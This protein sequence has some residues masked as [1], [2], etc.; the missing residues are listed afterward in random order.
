VLS[1]VEVTNYQSLRKADIRLGRLTVVTGPTGSGKSALFRAIR[2]LALNARG[3][4]YVSHGQKSCSVTAWGSQ[5][6]VRL[7][8]SAA[9][10]GRN[11]YQ[12]AEPGT[13]AARK[14]TKLNSQVPAD[15]TRLLGLS[16]LNFHRQ[17][18]QP[19]LLA[20]PPAEVARKLGELTNVS[21][22]LGAAAE[23]NRL[24]KG[25]Q[26]DLD[27]ARARR[28]ALMEEA[29]E[30]AGLRER[31]RACTAAEEALARA[32][33]AAARAERLR[34]LAGRLELYEAR[35]GQA[36]AEAARQAPPSLERLEALVRNRARLR[37]LTDRLGGEESDA[38]QLR[39]SAASA[40]AAEKAAEQAIHA[41]L[42]QAG[43]CPVCKQAV[44][45]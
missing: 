13:G 14:Y 41:A 19:Y 33:A 5:A 22:V 23:G 42:A 29:Q 28:D 20:L 37:E 3:T 38:R 4:S 27:A 15:V 6:V 7:T 2:M 30:F 43:R 31:R 45:A 16:E 39:K 21:L 25:Y 26:R 34:A 32:Q 44:A 10:G 1:R 24:R 8:R 40:R 18:D 17:L 36:R 35:T 11:E 12:V 9:R